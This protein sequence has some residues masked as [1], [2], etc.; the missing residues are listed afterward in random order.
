MTTVRTIDLEVQC[1]PWYGQLASP[2]NPDNY[3]VMAGWRDDVLGGMPGPVQ[4]LHFTSKE[5]AECNWLNLDGVDLLVAHNAMFEISWFLSRHKTEFLKFLKRGGR[6]LCT[7]QAEYILSNFTE[8]YPSLDETAPKYGGTPKI[9]AVKE[10]WKQGYRTS[11]IDPKLLLEYLAGPGGDVENTARC[12]Y[13]QA[14]LLQE[15]GQW[16]FFLQRCEALLAFAFCE[17]AGLY[18]DT[19]VAE[20]NLAEQEAELA[21]LRAQANKLLPEDLPAELEFNWGSDYHMSALLFGG[22]VKYRTRVPRT[23]AD[24]NVMY[25]KE[26]CHLWIEAHSGR[27]EYTSIDEGPTN[28][29]A[30][31]LW[32]CDRYKAGKNKG[33]PKVH[34]V[35]TST[36]QT[37]WDDTAW[38]FPGLIWID[39]LPEHIQDNFGDRGDWRGKRTLCDDKTPVY[40]TSSDV[41]DVLGKQGFESAK[42]LVRMAQLDKDN[43]TYYRSVELDKDGNVKKVK[44][45]LQYVQPDGIIHHN[46][47]LT[48]TATGRLSSSNPNLQNLPRDGTSKVKQM[49]TSRFG[50]K[51]RIV[52]VDYS[53]LEVVMLAALSGDENLLDKLVNGIDM[54]CLRLAAKLGEPY[55]D[56]LH[57]AVE[58][59]EHPEHK[60]YK[61]MRTD[62]KPPSFAAQYGAS[63]RGIAYATGV[64]LEYA[65]EFLATEAK[66]FPQSIQF[67]QVIRDAVE[68]TGMEPEGLHR[69]QRD[70]GG[71]SIYRRGYWAA[72]GGARY[73]FRQYPKW[74]RATRQHIMDYKDTQIANYW[75]QGEAFYLMAVSAGRVIRWL[76]ANEFFRTEEYPEGRA[77]LINNVHDALY[78]D[79]HE[80]VLREAALGT[81]AIMEDAPKY[82]S[83]HLGYNIGHVPFPAAAEAG[84]S[85]YQKEHL[86]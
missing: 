68:R 49:F 37:K 62:I 82:M 39:Q 4:H 65:E 25:E 81:K 5:D 21:E 41:L 66:L 22:P 83:E 42:L 60:R 16:G 32:T 78:L 33:L 64:T 20:R 6:V 79:V 10:L 61:Q 8:T 75:C 31:D 26:D 29:Y 14:A 80:D 18:V 45:M 76:I 24:G 52:E 9:D 63:A 7:Q 59:Q 57:K 23:D 13:G 2:H 72:P 69:E 38:Q 74:D 36:P 50:D 30:T 71:W 70:D 15:R 28:L 27:E 86:H 58:N 1:I 35:E 47:N 56:V 77:F 11:E 67:R 34:K 17:F 85:M 73:S 53:A 46:L 55:E 12:F 51:G 19:E 3:I 54:H 40:S 84:P 44:G 43:S 48:A